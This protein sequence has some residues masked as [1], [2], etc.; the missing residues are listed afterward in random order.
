MIASVIDLNLYNLSYFYQF[1]DNYEIN[2]SSWNCWSSI[3]CCFL[4]NY[5]S[6]N[7]YTIRKKFLKC[8]FLVSRYFFCNF[9]IFDYINNIKGN[10]WKNSFKNYYE[11]RIR[12]IVPTLLFVILCSSP[13]AYTI[14]FPEPFKDFSKSILSSIECKIFLQF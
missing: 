2:I 11:R 6:L 14:L 10:S 7:F 5:L 13:F 8:W 1:F 4:S 12:R 3:N 9:R